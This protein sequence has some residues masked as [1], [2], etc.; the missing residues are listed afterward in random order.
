VVIVVELG[1]TFAARFLDAAFLAVLAVPL[2]FDLRK[3][4]MMLIA[5]V[6][7]SAVIVGL[8]LW[9]QDV[10]FG[11]PFKTPYSF[12]TRPGAASDQSF[13][14]F[15]PGRIVTDFIGDFVTGRYHGARLGGDPYLRVAPWLVIAP[16]GMYFA[17][18]RRSP[19]R[20]FLICA[21]A[22][23]VI[24]SCAYLSFRAGTVVDLAFQNARYFVA[25]MPIWA[26]FACYGAS[27]LWSY[28]P[29]EPTETA[30]AQQAAVP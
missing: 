4:L 16:V 25:W 6:S 10:A 29:R 8:V 28:L 23:S 20:P 7:S 11:S 5:A 30:P 21:I 9:T 26:L 24:S 14:S 3:N 18:R 27:V 12:H 17:I 19:H 15:S 2:L 1:F 22:A 13:S